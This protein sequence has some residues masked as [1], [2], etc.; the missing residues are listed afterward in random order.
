MI[1]LYRDIADRP[2]DAIDC[3]RHL[4]ADAATVLR[5]HAFLDFWGLINT[6]AHGR[7]RFQ[8]TLMM[9][10][11]PPPPRAAGGV[12][13]SSKGKEKEDVR[14]YAKCAVTGE[15]LQRVCYACK[16]DPTFMI[17]PMAYMQVTAS[18]P[19]SH[20]YMQVTV[21]LPLSHFRQPAEL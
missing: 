21:P 19:L 12:T 5:V 14:G 7:V 9:L 18:L 13:G 8:K 2:L 11:E 3:L 17:T 1:S 4:A 6:D 10:S 16:A 20:A 15:P